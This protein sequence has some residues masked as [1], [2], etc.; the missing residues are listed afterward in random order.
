M[1]DNGFLGAS[2]WSGYHC[3]TCGSAIIEL[4]CR[5]TDIEPFCQWDWWVHCAN[6][7]C[8]N[9]EGEGLFQNDIEWAEKH[10]DCFIKN[11]YIFELS[12]G[13]DNNEHYGI[14]LDK[15]RLAEQHERNM[16]TNDGHIYVSMYTNGLDMAEQMAREIARDEWF[17]YLNQYR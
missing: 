8:E 16:V 14:K 11:R 13:N 15:I 5:R 9:H 17:C 1:N 2:V 12:V 4:H 7:C 6:P 3:K 10:D